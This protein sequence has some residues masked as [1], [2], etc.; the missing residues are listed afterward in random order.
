MDFM[1]MLGLEETG[2]M[3]DMTVCVLVWS[4]H[5]ECISA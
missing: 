5:K 2:E 1:Q 4:C 3:L